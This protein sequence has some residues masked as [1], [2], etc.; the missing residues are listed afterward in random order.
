[1]SLCT[2]HTV[3]SRQLPS[4]LV[5]YYIR[6]TTPGMYQQSNAFPFIAVLCVFSLYV[7]GT[8]SVFCTVWPGPPS[9]LHFVHTGWTWVN[10]CG[11]CQRHSVRV[12][13]AILFCFYSLDRDYVVSCTCRVPLACSVLFG[14]DYP[15]V[16]IL[17]ILVGAWVNWCGSCRRYSV[18]VLQRAHILSSMSFMRNESL[19]CTYSHY[20]SSST[21][22]FLDH[23]LS[24]AKDS[25]G[26]TEPVSTVKC[27]SLYCCIVRFFFV[28]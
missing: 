27:R 20:T 4:S 10:W 8:V 23:L 18:R 21:F 11:S 12:L 14:L 6:R 17:S 26:P 25:T 19:Y 5:T 9:G 7:H 16:C 3:L 22:L 13:P 2:T 28:R 24:Q 15:P 1:M